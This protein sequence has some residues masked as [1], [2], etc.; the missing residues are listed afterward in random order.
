MTRCSY[1]DFEIIFSDD[2]QFVIP[3]TGSDLLRISPEK[4]L[5]SPESI[6]YIKT[7]SRCWFNDEVESEK[8]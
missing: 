5:Y 8:D 4:L 6:S 7:W 3:A 1:K 2:K